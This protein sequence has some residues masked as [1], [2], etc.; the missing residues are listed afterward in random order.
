M[1][2]WAGQSTAG[3]LIATLLGLVFGWLPTRIHGRRKLRKKEAAWQKEIE[4][5][6]SG[7]KSA[8]REVRRL[9]SGLVEAEGAYAKASS[10]LEA[11]D[12]QLA[13]RDRTIERL[14]AEVNDAKAGLARID[15]LQRRL[16]DHQQKLAAYDQLRTAGERRSVLLAQGKA[17]RDELAESRRRVEEM[18]TERAQLVQTEASLTSELAH[19]SSAL[20]AMQ[21]QFAEASMEKEKLDSTV[22]HMRSKQQDHPV[23]EEMR[24]K[25]KQLEE[26]NRKLDSKRQTIAN[27]RAEL[28]QAR[29][30]LA[31]RRPAKNP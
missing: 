16:E 11:R 12:Q 3:L 7:S 1:F 30:E 8:A 31:A 23:A 18:E 25:A 21:A 17:M 9:K 20:G 28:E 24:S 10:Q 6:Q 29:S 2:D 26:L 4:S 22:H 13:M 5:C 14:I 15:E 19:A 27:L